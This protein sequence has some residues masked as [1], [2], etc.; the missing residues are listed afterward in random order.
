MQANEHVLRPG[1]GRGRFDSPEFVLADRAA[2]A[3][4]LAAVD[5]D[6]Q[7]VAEAQAAAIVEGFRRELVLHQLADVMVA[8]DAEDRQPAVR[9]MR[10]EAPVGAA[11]VVLDQVAG[12][13]D[14]VGAPVLGVDVREHGA[15]RAVGHGPAQ[16][17]ARLGEQVRVGDL[18]DPDGVGESFDDGESRAG[19]S[20][21]SGD[22]SPPGGGRPAPAEGAGP[23]PGVTRSVAVVV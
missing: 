1:I 3:A 19:R 12:H 8:R 6:E 21:G 14:D 22:N 2:G 23:V 4:G 11:A 13:R 18:Q 16:A 17:C 9:E 20:G 10:A 5:T 15:Q 7:P